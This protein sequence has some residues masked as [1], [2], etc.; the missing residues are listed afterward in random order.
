MMIRDII[1]IILII[2]STASALDKAI[3]IQV[4]RVGSSRITPRPMRRTEWIQ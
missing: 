3:D 4:R 1:L 2:L